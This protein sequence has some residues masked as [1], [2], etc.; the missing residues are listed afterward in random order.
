MKKSQLIPK[1]DSAKV[2]NEIDNYKF[3]CYTL[4]VLDK[5]FTEIISAECNQGLKLKTSSNNAIS[6]SETITPD[7]V[8]EIPTGKNGDYRATN[9]IKGWFPKDKTFWYDVAEQLKKYDDDLS[10]WKFNNKHRHDIMLTTDPAF[11]ADFKKYVEQSDIENKLKIDRNFAIIES[12]LKERAVNSIFIRKFSGKI[13]NSKLE[14]KLTS[15]ISYSMY[16]I[17]EDIEK[18]KFYDSKP[19]EIYTMMLM[20]DFVFPRFVNSRQKY[21]DIAQNKTAELDITID[22]IHEILS[23]FAPDTNPNCIEKNWIR[24]ALDWFEEMGIVK[25]SKT[26]SEKFTIKFRKH[27]EKTLDWLLKK[28]QDPKPIVVR[29]KEDSSLDEFLKKDEKNN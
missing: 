6:P 21:R 17:L 28:I 7:L 3:V 24:T 27:K 1:I 23:K 10:D 18:L 12:M 15:G 20:W 9:E 14:E 2:K 4:V 22:K 16:N 13:S 25:Q 29:G 19:P 11:T 8:I 5:I 26:N